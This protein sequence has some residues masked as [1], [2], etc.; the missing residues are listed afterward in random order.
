[1]LLFLAFLPE[2]G[3]FSAIV[4][5]AF[6]L[7]GTKYLSDATGEQSI[8][9]NMIVSAVVMVAGILVTLFFVFPGLSRV[10]PAGFFQAPVQVVPESNAIL[11]TLTAVLLT[12][13]LAWLLFVISAIFLRRSFNSLAAALGQNE[14]K[15][16]SVLY[17]LGALLVA[18]LIGFPIVFAAFVFQIY[19]FLS[20]AERF[21][22]AQIPPHGEIPPPPPDY[23]RT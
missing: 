11:G 1:L 8:L 15:T 12:L 7:V 22:V 13:G 21:P 16:S 20:V 9:G 10:L 2:I 14:F 3:P 4:G 6:V 19:A 17:L 23:V 5:A 18:L